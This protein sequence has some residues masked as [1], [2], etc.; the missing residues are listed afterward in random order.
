MERNNPYQE[1]PRFWNP[2]VD[3]RAAR[4]ELTKKLLSGINTAVMG[5]EGVGKSSFLRSVFTPEFSKRMAVE[6]HILINQINYPTDLATE[7]IYNFFAE[8]V[9]DA[10]EILDYCG[11]KEV[12]QNIM[13]QAKRY[14]A[15]NI[16]PQ[17]YFQRIC[18]Y[19]Y[20]TGYIVVLVIDQ[21]ERFTS[22]KYVLAEHHDVMRNVLIDK[23]LCFVVATD[24]DFNKGS[25]PKNSSGSLLLQLF[26]GHEILL[27]GLSREESSLFLHQ[28]SGREDFTPKELDCLLELTGGIP[29]LLCRAAC[30]ALTQKQ[31]EGIICWSGVTKSTLRDCGGLMERW[32]GILPPQE[33]DMLNT[34]A[35]QIES[36]V[37]ISADLRDGAAPL[38]LNRGLIVDLGDNCYNFNS[39]L[40]QEYCIQ[41]PPKPRRPQDLLTLPENWRS[42][43]PH[44]RFMHYED[45]STHIQYVGRAIEAGGVQIYNNAVQGI[46]IAEILSLIG[47]TG[48]PKT[49]LAARLA[50]KLTQSLS[51]D[52]LPILPTDLMTDE[53]QE[54]QGQIY[55]KA[56]SEMG[57]SFLTDLE[58]NE[59]QELVNISA[60]EVETLDKYFAQAHAN[61]RRDLT[62]DLLDSVSERCRLYLKLSVVVEN[63]LSILTGRAVLDC[64]PHLVLYGKALEQTLRDNLFHL[65]QQEKC[66]SVYDTYAHREDGRSPNSFRNRDAKGTVIGNFTCLIRAK[67]HYLGKLCAR[68]NICCAPV[69]K[70]TEKQ[71]ANWWDQFQRDIN[72]ARKIRNQ[73]DHP[74]DQFPQI[75]DLEKMCAILFGGSGT[76]GVLKRALVGKMLFQEL[77]PEK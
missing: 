31:K 52:G 4:Q 22:S 23:N 37:P 57:S 25:L 40:F 20:T 55:D 45:K 6:K 7:N 63:A 17:N 1:I 76:P 38:L 10:A 39:H 48:T 50:Q 74:G 70:M 77:F 26:A 54:R 51:A 59:E 36:A 18:K 47:E 14:R 43:L 21:F 67:K 60:R 28:I 12:H 30:Y 5:V 27:K 68:Q 65:F 34:M 19:M 66:L 8:A 49:S 44:S 41:T 29:T 75:D 53:E 69:G 2:Y 13:E 72:E 71:W 46:S 16:E 33:A 3:R 11:K 32:L 9:R 58:V 24:Y 73:A 15:E 42:R 61:C 64:S 56:F 62:D 35:G